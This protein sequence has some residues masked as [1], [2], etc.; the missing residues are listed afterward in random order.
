MLLKSVLFG[1]LFS[2]LLLSV[3]RFGQCAL[4]P[5]SGISCRT[6]ETS[7]RTREPSCRNREPSRNRKPSRNFRKPFIQSTGVSCSHT[8]NHSYVNYY[9]MLLLPLTRIEPAV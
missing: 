4:Q 1:L 6:R 7:F 2:S 3:Q 8:A 9:S 5:S